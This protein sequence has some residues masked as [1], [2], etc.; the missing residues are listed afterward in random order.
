[1]DNSRA[2]ALLRGC[3]FLGLLLIP[4][5]LPFLPNLAF[6]LLLALVLAV[7]ILGLLAGDNLS[8]RLPD[9]PFLYLFLFLLF[10][11]SVTSVTLGFS[12]R[13]ILLHIL[14][15]GL[16]VAI[17]TSLTQREGWSSFCWP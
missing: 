7:F 14:G 10:M 13:E 9:N 5:S 12:L 16:M 1:M 11:S 6:L 2:L 17:Y 4:L 15:W 8:L 3:Y